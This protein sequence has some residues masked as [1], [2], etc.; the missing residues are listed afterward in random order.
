MSPRLSGISTGTICEMGITALHLEEGRCGRRNVKRWPSNQII[1]NKD[2]P[3]YMGR[4]LV[5]C[6]LEHEKKSCMCR[7]CFMGFLYHTAF[8]TCFY[9]LLRHSCLPFFPR[10]L[11]VEY[12]PL[13]CLSRIEGGGGISEVFTPI[14]LRF[15]SRSCGLAPSIPVYTG[16]STIPYLKLTD[17]PVSFLFWWLVRFAI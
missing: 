3:R 1:T 10:V 5:F 4:G 12:L 15:S 16:E 2:G 6:L 13:E 7:I 17:G 9:F 11:R 14:I 8:L